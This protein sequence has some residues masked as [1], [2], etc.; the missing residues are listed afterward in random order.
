[1]YIAPKAVL[2]TGDDFC[3]YVEAGVNSLDE[4]AHAAL[5]LLQERS[6]CLIGIIAPPP[7]A[8]AGGNE[9]IA[10]QPIVGLGLDRSLEHDKLDNREIDNVQGVDHMLDEVEG[11]AATDDQV[12]N[13]EGDDTE[14]SADEIVIPGAACK[15]NGAPQDQTSDTGTKKSIAL[16]SF[17]GDWQDSFGGDVHVHRRLGI[18][19]LHVRF[20]CSSREDLLFMLTQHGDGSF[21]CGQYILDTAASDESL[22]VWAQ[23]SGPKRRTWK[24][25]DAP[26]KRKASRSRSLTKDILRKHRRSASPPGVAANL[27]GSGEACDGKSS[28]P[29]DLQNRLDS[30]LSKLT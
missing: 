5:T 9:G 27:S 13:T 15:T 4:V 2:E 22:M 20:V 8:S 24:R 23:A 11:L 12:Q 29:A 17:L 26:R 21:Q 28:L 30:L 3:S 10:A 19:E 6:T 18:Q 14:D 7:F 25:V 16:S 1:L